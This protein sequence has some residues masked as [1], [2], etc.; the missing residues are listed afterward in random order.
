MSL[1]RF[2]RARFWHPHS[3]RMRDTA[4]S[5]IF[6]IAWNNTRSI[7]C[8]PPL[9]LSECRNCIICACRRFLGCVGVYVGVLGY[10]LLEIC[11]LGRVVVWGHIWGCAECTV[12]VCV[13]WADVALVSCLR[14]CL[15]HSFF[16]APCQ[17]L[18]PRDPT[19]PSNSLEVSKDCFFSRLCKGR[20]GPLL[21]LP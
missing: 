7:L 18:G 2:L 6:T 11:V 12:L 17:W 15:L 9:S 5:S 14:F 13:M 21:A 8:L 19:V 3:S 10:Y 20:V 1:F 16:F 4:M